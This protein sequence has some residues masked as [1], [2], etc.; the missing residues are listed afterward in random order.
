MKL[1]SGAYTAMSI[2]GAVRSGL[3]R[4]YGAARNRRCEAVEFELET[5][6][7]RVSPILLIV[8]IVK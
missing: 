3:L 1:P 2:E 8:G 5:L 6:G 4:R 7:K